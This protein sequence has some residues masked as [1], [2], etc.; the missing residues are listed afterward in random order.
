EVLA[1]DFQELR[2][3]AHLCSVA[4]F[5][6]LL[7]SH[8]PVYV[9]NTNRTCDWQGRVHG[10]SAR[11][12]EELPQAKRRFE[13]LLRSLDQVLRSWADD[14]ICWRPDQNGIVLRLEIDRVPFL[15]REEEL[16]LGVEV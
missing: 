6:E 3:N 12:P 4:A 15:G 5:F 9:E 1:P 2:R 7:R 11:H 16:L 8:F 14:G 13:S 10:V